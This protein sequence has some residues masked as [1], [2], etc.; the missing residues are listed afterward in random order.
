MRAAAMNKIII[1]VIFS[2]LWIRTNLD[3]VTAVISLF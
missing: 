2:L 1:V 3:S